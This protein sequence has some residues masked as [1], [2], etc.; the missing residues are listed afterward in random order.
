MDKPAKRRRTTLARWLGARHGEPTRVTILF[1]DILGSTALSNKLGDAGWVERLTCHFE[2]GSKLVAEHDGYKIK[3]IGDSF[4]VA[5][6]TP[7]NALRFATAFH[8]DPATS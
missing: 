5:F 1:T 2:Q 6:K 3:F 7:L 8:R 4:M